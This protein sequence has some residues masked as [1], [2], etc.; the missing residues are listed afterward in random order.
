MSGK[1]LYSEING[2]FHLYD[3]SNYKRHKPEYNK[4]SR[5]TFSDY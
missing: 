5:T 3:T 2:I 4:A 1:L